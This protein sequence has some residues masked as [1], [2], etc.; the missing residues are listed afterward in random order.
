MCFF[1]R[2][3]LPFWG[4]LFSSHGR[5]FGAPSSSACAAVFSAAVARVAHSS[6][7]HHK[8]DKCAAACPPPPRGEAAAARVLFRPLSFF[9]RCLQRCLVSFCTLISPFRRR[10]S[11]N[12]DIA[13]DVREFLEEEK[14]FTHNP[15]EEGAQ[16]LLRARWPAACR[17]TNHPPMLLVD[18]KNSL[19]NPPSINVASIPPP[20]FRHQARLPIVDL[21]RAYPRPLLLPPLQTTTG[22]RRRAP[23]SRNPARLSTPRARCASCAGRRRPAPS[24]PPF[25][26]PA[27]CLLPACSA[28]SCLQAAAGHDVYYAA[29][30]LSQHSA[31]GR[32]CM[33]VISEG[34]LK[35]G[36]DER[37][38]FMDEEGKMGHVQRETIIASGP[39]GGRV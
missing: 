26:P 37:R 36:V 4:S 21:S 18:Q 24:L 27:A 2:P 39:M 1:C 13:E 9:R 25:P 34:D 19:T 29:V 31:V 38:G 15:V 8:P 11:L 20:F 10:R 7:S 30:R 12:T 35:E 22:W 5:S 14:G 3:P 33:Q 32:L 17:R 16:Q 23:S 6:G 28:G